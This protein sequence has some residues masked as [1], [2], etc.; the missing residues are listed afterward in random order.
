MHHLLPGYGSLVRMSFR[1]RQDVE[2]GQW[3]DYLC[4]ESPIGWNQLSG[5]ITS[6]GL[7]QRGFRGC[8][9][10]SSMNIHR[11]WGLDFV[12]ASKAWETYSMRRRLFGKCKPQIAKDFS[13]P[14][15][16]CRLSYGWF[17]KRLFQLCAWGSFL[18]FSSNVLISLSEFL[19]RIIFRHWTWFYRPFFVHIAKCLSVPGIVRTMSSHV[20]ILLWLGDRLHYH[21]SWALSVYLA[22]G[23]ASCWE[24]AFEAEAFQDTRSQSWAMRFNSSLY[25]SSRITEL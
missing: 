13:E 19:S 5:R 3:Y 10:A 21:V 24:C 9:L 22:M 25:P 15:T 6:T 8:V 17:R 2:C 11:A 7:W 1:G 20:I 16:L 4:D 14:L 12:W 23:F 18:S